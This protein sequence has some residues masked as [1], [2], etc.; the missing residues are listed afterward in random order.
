MFN[1]FCNTPPFVYTF[2]L[3]ID[4]TDESIGL[5]PIF[6]KL[7]TKNLCST[8]SNFILNRLLS[9][10]F[11]SIYFSSIGLLDVTIKF[12]CA[13]LDFPQLSV[14][15]YVI[16]WVP[17]LELLKSLW[18]IETTLASKLSSV[19]LSKS[20]VILLFFISFNGSNSPPLA[21]VTSFKDCI[22]GA[23]LVTSFNPLFVIL[24]LLEEISWLS[25][26]L[27]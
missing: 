26:P 1:V 11:N 6:S 9:P 14:T 8:E 12:I 24:N 23:W 3:N 16:V 20:S 15:V 17:T 21:I 4:D 27:E 7:S 19:N 18:L 10:S 22:W 5:S 13:V 25:I 2:N